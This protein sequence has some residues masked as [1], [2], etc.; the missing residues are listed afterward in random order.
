MRKL[1]TAFA[2]V[3][4]LVSAVIAGPRSYYSQV[5]TGTNTSGSAT[6]AAT[7]YIE[8]LYVS[9]SDGSSTGGVRVSYA[10]LAGSTAVV[11]ATNDVAAEAVFRPR[12][13]GTDTTG[14]ALTSDPPGRFALAG[15]TMTFVVS[16]SP[17]GVVWKCVIIIDD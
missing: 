17:T 3:V 9:V 12:V 1:L 13:D 10:P 14:S 8:A 11:L 7:G 2:L 16:G 5:S 15:E 6:L 4:A